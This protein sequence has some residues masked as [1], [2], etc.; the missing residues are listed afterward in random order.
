MT[1][2]KISDLTAITGASTASDDLF[3]MVDSS[4]GV[5]KKITRAE[6][7]NALERDTFATVDIDSGTIDG[8][9]IG[10]STPAAISGTTITGTSFV[11][12][13]DMTFGDDDKAIFGAGSDL[14]IYHD[15]SNSYIVDNGTGDLF[16]RAENNLYLK[17]TNSDETY[18]SGAVND[19]V[20]L[21]HNNNPK[22]ATTISGVDVTGTV[23]ADGLTIDG[24]NTLRLNA[25]S[26]TDFFTIIQGG[27]QAVLTADSPDGAGN[28]LFKT[29]A[30]G[31]DTDRMQIASNGDISFYEDTGTTAKFF[32]DA[33]A[34]RLGIGTVS[35]VAPF[36]VKGDTVRFENS[37]ATYYVGI[38]YDSS[39]SLISQLN[40]TGHLT[41]SGGSA[42]G[43]LRF[44]TAGSEAMRITS[45]G[46]VGIGTVSPSAPLHVKS[47]TGNSKVIFEHTS[48][49]TGTGQTSMFVD[50]S[51]NATVVYDNTGSYIIGTASNPVTGAGFAERMRIDSSGNLLI[52]SSSLS[53]D[54]VSKTVIRQVGDNWTIKPYICHSFNRTDSDGS[55]LEFYK[56]SS[57]VG[58]I[59]TASGGLTFGSG[60]SGTERMRIDS[61]GNLLVGTSVAPAVGV[62]GMGYG[63]FPINSYDTSLVLSYNGTGGNYEV[64]FV[65]N[66][67]LVGT[68]FTSG[69]A[70][71]Y[72][73]S[74]DYRLKEDWQP[75][76]GATERVKA[77][78][79][80]NFAWKADG[81]RV[82]GFL[83]HE[84]QE[85]VPEAVTGEKDAMREEQYE[86]TPAVLDED[87]NVV[88]E[89]V[90]GTR[91]VPD[92]QGIDQSKLVPLLT[93][94]LQEAIAEIETLKTKV[95]A[96]ENA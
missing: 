91:Q 93:A 60:S 32:W 52:G 14:Q 80:V 17:R 90:M 4:E 88:T 61:S 87:G 49:S 26:T 5:T 28:M 41:L 76:T 46:S 13:G 92:Y 57:L 23:T 94:A 85:V 63:S 68:I 59:G 8:T 31:V 34:E 50:G 27:T 40:S 10:G 43:T 38:S 65:N 51:S 6:L 1:D 33:S 62:T 16:I 36:H 12:S 39:G 71:S 64:V 15:G 37:A 83:A 75:M 42:S 96:L 78:N 53:F 70:T 35:P 67:G 82:D 73:T 44:N 74:S 55:I 79:P 66:N 30:A 47:S 69:S 72:N 29:A 84:A 2:K 19:A 3:V 54:N 7:N 58:S 77:L 20:T 89:A 81:S 48:P 45:G 9:T 86:V 22:L 24:G 21:Y 18:L 11:S 25:A 95:A 56:S